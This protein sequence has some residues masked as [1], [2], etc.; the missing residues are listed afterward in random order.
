ML[1]SGT[2]RS[3]PRD[4]LRARTRTRNRVAKG[5]ACGTGT[6]TCTLALMAQQEQDGAHV[7]ARHLWMH[8]E[9]LHAA[10]YYSPESTEEYELAGLKGWAA[11]MA[12]RSAPLGQVP[13]AVVIASFFNF[14]PGLIK[15]HVPSCWS[16]CTPEQAWSARLRGADR[17]LRRLLGP[18]S[19]ES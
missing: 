10:A 18:Q 8:L 9:P 15:R 11:Y 12:G 2:L 19:V 16:A 4:P 6:P 14:A 1:G 13:A 17:T 3:V 5:M 7:M